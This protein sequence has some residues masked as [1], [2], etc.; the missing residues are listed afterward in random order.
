ME[1]MK[2][3]LYIA[4][5]LAHVLTTRFV[6]QVMVFGPGSFQLSDYALFWTFASG[7]MNSAQPGPPLVFMVESES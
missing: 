5:L 7:S 6:A 4:L 1:C 2:G 3:C